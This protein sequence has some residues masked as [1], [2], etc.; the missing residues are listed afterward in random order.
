MDR[1]VSCLFNRKKAEC[2]EEL[3]EL[4][5]R[6]GWSW[7]KLW[8][9]GE[10]SPSK[11]VIMPI[12]QIAHSYWFISQCVLIS[13][14]KEEWLKMYCSYITLKLSL[15]RRN[16]LIDRH[17]AILNDYHIAVCS[18]IWKPP[19]LFWII[20]NNCGPLAGAL[21]LH[22]VTSLSVAG[23]QLWPGYAHWAGGVCGW[24]MAGDV[25]L[26]AWMP[27]TIWAVGMYVCHVFS[28]LLY[29]EFVINILDI[30]IRF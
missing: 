24:W 16:V 23:A 20:L 22:S 25:G 2:Q 27:I 12:A 4:L 1:W 18:S 9:E 3:A 17:V 8:G 30:Y 5:I 19:H 21:K 13:E 28:L 11:S 10:K 6:F 14:A 29:Y 26:H 7:P 15:Y